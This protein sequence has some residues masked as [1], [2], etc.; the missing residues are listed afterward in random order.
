MIASG[1]RLRLSG[2]AAGAGGRALE[3]RPPEMEMRRRRE[4]ARARAAAAA[5]NKMCFTLD[6][7]LSA[8]GA[9]EEV[10]LAASDR[11]TKCMRDEK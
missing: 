6:F 7:S 2:T 8:G 5:R 9:A 4:R 11:R 3:E 10:C 1:L